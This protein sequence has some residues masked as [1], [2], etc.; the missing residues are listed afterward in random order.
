MQIKTPPNPPIPSPDSA[1]LAR[2]GYRLG[3]SSAARWRLLTEAAALVA[4][5]IAGPEALKAVL[6]NTLAFLSLQDGA[7]MQVQGDGLL[8]C[9]SA[10]LMPPVGGRV[11]ATDALQ[12]V[13]QASQQAP[14][15]RQDV[16]SRLRMGREMVLGLEVLVPLRFEGRNRG[17]LAVAS[18]DRAPAP[19][20]E[21]LATLQALGT[22]LAAAFAASQPATSRATQG[23]LEALQALLTPRE[24]EVFALLP[25]GMTNMEMGQHLGI[26]G[27]T[28]KVHVER[29]LHKLGLGDR[30]QAAVR[31]TECGLA[32]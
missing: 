7:L 13:M 3:E 10:G 21:D 29:I 6:A 5:E 24:F 12:A 2:R 11:R 16:V 20:T 14:L 18:A 1:R 26:A 15:V 27:G 25:S 9:A 31:A 23:E 28:V 19:S 17:V 32:S 4:N 8:V 22:L 30:T